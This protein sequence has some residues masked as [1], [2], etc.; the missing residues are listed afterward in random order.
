MNG[1]VKKILFLGEMGHFGFKMA[2]HHNSGSALRIFFFEI[3]IMKGA[4]LYMQ[5]ILVVFPK[6]IFWANGPFWVQR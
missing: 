6:K 5:I 3:C 2:H 4:K 1:F